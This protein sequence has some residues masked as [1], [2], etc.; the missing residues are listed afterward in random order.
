MEG[1]PD[2]EECFRRTPLPKYLD[3]SS[4]HIAMAET[5]YKFEGW[6]GLDTSA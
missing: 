5:D 1:G 6:M 2:G 3:P 4:I